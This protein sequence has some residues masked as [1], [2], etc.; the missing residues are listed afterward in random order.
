MKDNKK[1]IYN[2]GEKKYWIEII[3]IIIL[4]VVVVK[5][6]RTKGIKKPRC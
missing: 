4:V 2:K 5:Q 3:I 6:K 1:Q